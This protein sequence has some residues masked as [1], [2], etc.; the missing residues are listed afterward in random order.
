ALPWRAPDARRRPLPRWHV[1]EPV[2]VRSGGRADGTYHGRRSPTGTSRRKPGRKPFRTTTRSRARPGSRRPPR[3]VRVRAAGAL[4]DLRP[5]TAL[6]RLPDGVALL[7]A[8][9][10]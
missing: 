5:R 6:R 10:A 1:G 3:A 7:L 4:R 2:E 9:R 8:E